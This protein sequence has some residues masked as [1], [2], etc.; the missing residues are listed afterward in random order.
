[1]N[2][3]IKVMIIVLVTIIAGTMF[4][5]GFAIGVNQIRSEAIQRGVAEYDAET[6]KWGWKE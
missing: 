2:D 5:L 1:M 3:E 6:A 4:W